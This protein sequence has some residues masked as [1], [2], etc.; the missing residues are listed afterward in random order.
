MNSS[1][2]GIRNPERESLSQTS[3]YSSGGDDEEKTFPALITNIK[4][5]YSLQ[6]QIQVLENNSSALF[7][8]LLKFNYFLRNGVLLNE[9]D[10]ENIITKKTIYGRNELKFVAYQEVSDYLIFVNYSN[11]IYLRKADLQD[12]DQSFDVMGSVQSIDFHPYKHLWMAIATKNQV[13]V[14]NPE[15]DDENLMASLNP[16]EHGETTSTLSKLGKYLT[17]NISCTSV[18]FSPDGRYLAMINEHSSAVHLWDFETKKLKANSEFGLT[19]NKIEWS[20]DGAYLALS[21][22]KAK[23]LYI[24]EVSTWK[25]QKWILKAPISQ[26]SWSCD[27][28]IL[29]IFTKES[30]EIRA[31]R[32]VQLEKSK[33]TFERK[34]IEFRMA[35]VYALKLEH[36]QQ[37]EAFAFY[38]QPNRIRYAYTA[39]IEGR[40]VTKLGIIEE[41]NEEKVCE[42]MQERPPV[43]AFF[44]IGK[45]RRP[46]EQNQPIIYKCYS[47]DEIGN[48]RL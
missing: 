16:F 23:R 1:N 45:N 10:I 29:Y 22:D 35:E 33:T 26:M 19:F 38:I 7:K 36:H 18:K 21:S 13:K 24:T 3:R 34:E 41:A 6:H 31:V 8:S 43:K 12:V 37:L 15:T 27:A 11:K 28:N 32:D 2:Q 4:Y 14:L 42:I 44:F 47:K 20:P 9:T 5:L 30:L 39:T 46:Y 48:I 40:E 25:N 17:L